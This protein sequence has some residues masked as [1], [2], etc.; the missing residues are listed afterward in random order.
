MGELLAPLGRY[1][2][3]AALAVTG[4]VGEVV[5]EVFLPFIMAYIIDRGAE[6]GGGLPAGDAEGGAGA[7]GLDE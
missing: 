1:R 5:M 6:A 2:R 3:E 4:T 7:H